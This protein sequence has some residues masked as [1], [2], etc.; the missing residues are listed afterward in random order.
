MSKDYRIA[1][2]G[3]YTQKQ[4]TG[5]GVVNSNLI[6]R[7]MDSSHRKPLSRSSFDFILYSNSG[8][9]Q[10]TYPR[11]TKAITN[12]LSPD[13]GFSG[14][15]MRFFWYQSLF[16]WQLKYH[17]IS[18][19]YS[20]I[21]EGMLF[22]IVPQIVT[23]YDLIPL[24]YPALN[25]KWQYYYRYI[26]PIILKNSA[27]IICCSEHTKKDVIA[28]YQLTDKVIRVVYP[29]FDR[30][31]FYP[32]LNP[33]ILTKYGLKKYIL[34]VGDMRTYKNLSR[35]LD[36]FQALPLKE[37]QFAIV[38]TK[39][40][41]FYP[42]IKQKTQKLTIENR[43]KFLDYVPLEDLPILYSQA[44]TLVFASLYEGFG[45]PVLEAMACG[46]PVVALKLT[47]IPEVGAD[48][49]YYVDPYS[50]E[51]ITQGLYRILTDKNLRHQLRDRGLNRAKLFSWS[52]MAR[53]TLQVLQE[54]LS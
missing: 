45:L 20:P 17:D 31:I 12:F 15:L 26:L 41:Y 39:D 52:Q 40:P 8:D 6:A 32:Q 53:D 10:K 30:Q 44:T 48:S 21:S 42:Q 33:D 22:P 29:G 2:N 51:S 19:F 54:H 7:L 34:F 28:N 49:I 43:V 11:Q 50:T 4:A 23:V 5:L 27:A 36:A 24:K 25:P 47:S 14:H 16:G 3:T 37:Y 35:C 18:L 1:I 46:C 9:F 38:G 13:Y